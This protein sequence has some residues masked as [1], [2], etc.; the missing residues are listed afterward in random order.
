VLELQD[1]MILKKYV[2]GKDDLIYFF[3]Q[4]KLIIL[5]NLKKQKLI[6]FYLN[7]KKLKIKNM[8]SKIF[9]PYKEM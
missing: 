4:S 2:I 5:C 7:S 3:I 9:N 1:M 8:I 6:L